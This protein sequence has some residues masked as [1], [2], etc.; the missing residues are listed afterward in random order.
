MFSCQEDKF[1]KRGAGILA[2]EIQL[3]VNKVSIPCP[4]DK[5]GIVLN[6]L[7]KI[8]LTG[9]EKTDGVLKLYKKYTLDYDGQDV[10][11][12]PNKT[13]KDGFQFTYMT[14]IVEHSLGEKPVTTRDEG[15]IWLYCDKYKKHNIPKEK[16]PQP[17]GVH[18]V[19][20]E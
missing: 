9:L 14:D 7:D 18:M 16:A 1:D 11:I 6:E 12:R 20:V 2:K 4:V 3:E 19:T 15:T 10:T 13:T 5:E 17:T 8:T